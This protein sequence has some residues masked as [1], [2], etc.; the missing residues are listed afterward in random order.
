MKEASL[1]IYGAANQL[2]D[3][4]DEKERNRFD[5]CKIGCSH[6]FNGCT[7][8]ETCKYR[9]KKCKCACGCVHGAQYNGY[10]Y[11]CAAAT[12]YQRALSEERQ[13]KPIVMD[14]AKRG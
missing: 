9:I 14:Y 11:C 2:Q 10:C 3:E 4:E 5:G 12:E 1:S 8:D 7:H 6:A 13:V